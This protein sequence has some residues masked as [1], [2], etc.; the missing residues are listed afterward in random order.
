MPCLGP[1][2]SAATLGRLAPTTRCEVA[3]R[4][5]TPRPSIRS[6]GWFI[7]S[8]AISGPDYDGSMRE[9]DNLFCASIVA[10]KAKT[11]EYAWHFQQ[12]HHDIWD[13]DAASPVVLFDTVINGLPRKGIA[14]AG[15]TGWVYILDRTNGKPLIGIEER[16][17]PQEPRQ[18]T[19]KTQPYPVGDAT[20]PQCAE[21]MEGYEKAGCIFEPFWEEPVLIQP[22][23]Q[24]GT[25][26]SPMPYSPDT[27]YFYVPGTIRT[28]VFSRVPSQ[29]TT[30]LRYTNGTQAPPIGSPLSGTFTAINSTTNKIAWQDQMPYRMGGGGG[31]TV[32]AG[33][34]LLRGEP[35]GNR[36]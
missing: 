29:Y 36:S 24:G 15:R 20:V 3:R 34:L 14:E 10:L 5:G 6:L 32:T 19:A 1:A 30:G 27:G 28:S 11:G 13:Y 35:D 8:P 4:S 22:S 33:G 12:V 25:N 23:G 16:G 2:S 21:P 18:K 31:S 26:W 17:V 7:S 9:G